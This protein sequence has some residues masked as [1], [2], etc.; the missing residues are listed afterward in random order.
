LPIGSFKA[1]AEHFEIDP[2][3]V[4]KL[5]SMTMKDVTGYQPNAPI[6]PSTIVSNLPTTAFDTKFNN[7]GQKPKKVPID[8]TIHQQR[9]ENIDLQARGSTRFV[10]SQVG[11]SKTTI[12]RMKKEKQIKTFVMSLKPKLNDGCQ[13]VK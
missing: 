2:K 6:N 3:T 8:T 5:W 9:M 12:I 4:A 11:L 13:N 7:A 10:A 1:V